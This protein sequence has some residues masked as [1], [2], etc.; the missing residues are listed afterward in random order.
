M[1]VGPVRLLIYLWWC[2]HIDSWH[3]VFWFAY[4]SDLES[5]S[6]FVWS[7][8][9]VLLCQHSFS[10]ALVLFKHLFFDVRLFHCIIV[11]H[12]LECLVWWH[13]MSYVGYYLTLGHTPSFSSSDVL[14]IF[15]TTRSISWSLQVVILGNTSFKAF[16][17][18]HPPLFG[19]IISHSDF[20]VVRPI[21][22]SLQVII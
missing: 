17:L 16:L 4:I 13:S 15:L 19:F 8:I 10:V 3:V 2:T 22:W 1:M 12:I 21:C 9:L 7:I 18:G 6:A 5:W 20:M 14:Q 11:E